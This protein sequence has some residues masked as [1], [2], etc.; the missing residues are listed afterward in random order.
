MLTHVE[1]RNDMKFLVDNN[2]SMRLN[3]CSEEVVESVGNYIFL[4][5]EIGYGVMWKVIRKFVL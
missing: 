5:W 4:C 3:M 1:N 2:G